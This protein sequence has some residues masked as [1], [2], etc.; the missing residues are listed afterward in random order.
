MLHRKESKELYK[1]RLY[2]NTVHTNT[3]HK[4]LKQKAPAPQY[5]YY[6]EQYNRKNTAAE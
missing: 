6:Y 2:Y 3:T 1:Y 5:I 4:N